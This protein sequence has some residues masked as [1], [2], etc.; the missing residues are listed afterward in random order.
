[1]LN[2][3]NSIKI[4]EYGTYFNFKFLA[5]ILFHKYILSVYYQKV[6]IV[7]LPTLT[8]EALLYF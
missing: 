2:N 7:M 4:N 3:V 8:S 6:C 1:M 5:E